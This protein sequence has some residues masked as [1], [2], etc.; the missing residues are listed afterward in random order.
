MKTINTFGKQVTISERE[1]IWNALWYL[2]Q[3]HEFTN[4]VFFV[5]NDDKDGIHL[6]G[7]ELS[8][9]CNI[10]MKKFA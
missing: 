9:L 1:F 10:L 6:S 8:K 4:H 7:E 5:R 2:K 3:T